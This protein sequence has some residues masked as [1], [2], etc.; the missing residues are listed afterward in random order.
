MCAEINALTQAG[1]GDPGFERALEGLTALRDGEHATAVERLSAFAERDDRAGAA[2]RILVANE[3]IAWGRDGLQ[4]RPDLDPAALLAEAL[5]LDPH[6][7]DAYWHLGRRY[8]DAGA[9][10]AAWV[11]FDAGRALPGREATP[12]LDQV[13]VMERRIAALAPGFTPAPPDDSG[14]SPPD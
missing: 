4:Q 6:A 8:L 12:L 5:I 13:G 7:P 1:L 11:F 9:P 3:L 14:D 2:A 10:L